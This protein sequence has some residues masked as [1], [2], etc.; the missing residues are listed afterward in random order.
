MKWLRSGYFYIV[1][2]VTTTIYT[3]KSFLWHY[4]A[5]F[6]AKGD[7]SDASH[8]VASRWARSI[9]CW[10]PGWTIQVTGEEHL[11]KLGQACVI[12][13]NHESGTDILAMYYLGIQFRWLAKKEL[14]S[15]PLI[16]S[17]MKWAGYVP[18]VRTNT[19]SQRQALVTS[20]AW[21]KKG[22]PMFFFPEGTRSTTGTLKKFKKGAFKL[23]KD[24]T[25]PIL[26]VCI[27]GAG[28]L[29]QKGTMI[30]HSA[31]VYVKVLPQIAINEDESVENFANRVQNEISLHHDTL[32]NR[33]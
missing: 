27:K 9:M 5:Q 30:P 6:S 3:A 33:A 29:L 22:T 19:D 2:G 31:T 7:P 8:K 14:F 26:P 25:V 10:T 11:P 16:G 18:I 21:L 1:L 17:S 32:G 28:N 13:A 15:Y 23:A 20:A 12:V 24:C 4:Y